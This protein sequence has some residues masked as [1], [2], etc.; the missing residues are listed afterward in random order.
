MSKK[1][2]AITDY[3]DLY[4]NSQWQWAPRHYSLTLE[5]LLDCIRQPSGGIQINLS[6]GGIK[7]SNRYPPL[8]SVTSSTMEDA[9][10]TLASKILNSSVGT[11]VARKNIDIILDKAKTYG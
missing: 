3:R 5:Q 2:Y 10:L 7:A 8:V 11:V 6:K 4:R 1:L 9:V